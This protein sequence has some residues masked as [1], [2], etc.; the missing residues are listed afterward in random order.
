LNERPSCVCCTLAETVEFNWDRDGIN[1]GVLTLTVLLTMHQH[2]LVLFSS[3]AARESEATAI[4]AS[5][6]TDL[7]AQ[8]PR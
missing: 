5:D 1:F 6:G 7:V 4:A 3:A 8:T 2:F